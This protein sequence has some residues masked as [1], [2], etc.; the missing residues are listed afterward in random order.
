MSP[1]LRAK[2]RVIANHWLKESKRRV[3]RSDKNWRALRAHV[4]PQED[5]II[6]SVYED[7]AAATTLEDC[8]RKILVLINSHTGK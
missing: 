2:L 4:L 6:Y 3:R 8:A 5:E 7:S 1:A